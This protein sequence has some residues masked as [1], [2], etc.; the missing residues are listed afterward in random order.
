MHLVDTHCHL[1]IMQSESN[2]EE[3]IENA[4]NNDIYRILVPGID[5]ESS[6]QA[7][8][9][10]EQFEIVY[11]AIGFHPNDAIK[12][13]ED[14]Y[15]ILHD[16][17]KH[18]KVKAIGE[19]GLDFYREHSPKSIQ[20]HVFKEQLKL[21]ERTG[22]PVV[23]HSR[24]AIDEIFEILIKWQQI[25]GISEPDRYLGIMH[26]FEGNLEQANLI[27]KHRFLLGIGG[28]ITFK[29]SHDKHEIVM[30]LPIDS[31]LLETDSPFLSPLPHRGKP[32]EPANI[33]FIAEKIAHLTEKPLKWVSEVT[34]KN[35]N[36][37]FTWE[38]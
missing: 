4:I 22:L 29:N 21:S 32:N 9:I 27:T 35:A 31:I 7:I 13:N 28:P 1:N 2:L 19:I 16:L 33:K 6:L 25:I 23:I 36:K 37:I 11:A 17:T 10:A 20:L 5:L 14:S 24:N 30:K 26:A 12:W 38:Q 3:I 34:T 8:K 18:P 15:S